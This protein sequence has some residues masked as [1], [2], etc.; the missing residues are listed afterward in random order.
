LGFCLMG[1][2]IADAESEFGTSFH[3]I[4]W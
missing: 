2:A 1:K 3:V 4:E